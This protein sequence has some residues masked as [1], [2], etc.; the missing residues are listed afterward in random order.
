MAGEK[1]ISQGKPEPRS[2][3]G[4]QHA[5]PKLPAD[6][7]SSCFPQCQALSG[8]FPEITKTLVL[9]VTHFCLLHPNSASPLLY[10]NGKASFD[11]LFFLVN[12]EIVSI[13][14]FL[15]FPQHF[16]QNVSKA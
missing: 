2:C 1:H 12:I 13:H 16:L 4:A 14:F 5:T 7:D 10:L 15:S 6:Q 11:V 8:D 9:F 3:L